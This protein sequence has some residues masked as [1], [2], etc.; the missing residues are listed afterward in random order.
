MNRFS[1]SGE[2]RLVVSFGTASK[3]FSI[4]MRKCL[5]QLLIINERSHLEVAV[6]NVHMVYVWNMCPLDGTNVVLSFFK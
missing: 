6:E 1:D 3:G 2:Q 4:F 5:P